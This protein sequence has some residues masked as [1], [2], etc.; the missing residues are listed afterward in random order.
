MNDAHAAARK[1]SDLKS[2]PPSVLLNSE[3]L[4][5]Y[6]KLSFQEELHLASLTEMFKRAMDDP[7]TTS[8]KLRQAMDTLYD[9]RDR[10]NVASLP[11]PPKAVRR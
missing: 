2:G 8:G 10:V 1:L 9:L 3:Q 11:S 6:L 5:V 4:K 7:L